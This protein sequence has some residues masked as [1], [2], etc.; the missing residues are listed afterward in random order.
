MV[1]SPRN[2]NHALIMVLGILDTKEP[3]G[4]TAF[5]LLKGLC[6]P[7]VLRAGLL[8][9]DDI[10]SELLVRAGGQHLMASS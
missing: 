8:D 6:E 4:A 2:Y 5:L 1:G 9:L 3:I 7:P 10:D